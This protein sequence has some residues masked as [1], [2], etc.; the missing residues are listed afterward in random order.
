MTLSRHP[1]LPDDPCCKNK[2]VNNGKVHP[3][4]IY[5]ENADVPDIAALNRPARYVSGE[6]QASVSA[7]P[8]IPECGTNIPKMMT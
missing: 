6:D 7:Q 4:S 8:C 2:T 1:P 3:P 5:G